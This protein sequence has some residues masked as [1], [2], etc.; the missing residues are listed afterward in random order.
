LGYA[1]HSSLSLKAVSASCE[2]LEIQ[3][4][5]KKVRRLFNPCLSKL[6]AFQK[7]HLT[8]TLLLAEPKAVLLVDGSGRL[9]TVKPGGNGLI[10]AACLLGANRLLCLVLRSGEV[11][12]VES[13]TLQLRARLSLS[14]QLPELKVVSSSCGT[15]LAI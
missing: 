15:S 6:V 11:R 1:E 4:E 12:V 13:S 9:R 8:D 14:C 7:N 10:A 5:S 2:L 3:F